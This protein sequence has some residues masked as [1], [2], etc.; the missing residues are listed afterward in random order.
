[1][2]PHPKPRR[3]LGPALIAG[4]ALLC[5]GCAEELGPVP[6]PVARVRGVVRE[7]DRPLRGG[8]I[9]FIPTGGTIGNL[10][11]ARLAPDGSFD[12][13]GVAV[14][15]NAIRVVDAP[16]EAAAH[17]MLFAQPEL[18]W[19]AI[20]RGSDG[21][22]SASAPARLFIPFSSP[23]RRAVAAEAAAPLDVDVVAE[24]VKFREERNR[25]MAVLPPATETETG[26]AP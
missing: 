3:A 16:I 19:A 5:V 13:D 18:K 22:V 6:M 20:V 23:I 10:R 21:R 26:E 4:A 9:E 1:M 24:A 14:G 17:V 12:A 25:S 15:V 11:S 8:W 2:K 7:G